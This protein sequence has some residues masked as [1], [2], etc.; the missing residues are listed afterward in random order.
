MTG[1][2]FMTRQNLSIFALAALARDDARGA[3]VFQ[4][5]SKDL[6]DGERI[7]MKHVYNAFGCGGKN[8][9]PELSWDNPPLGTKSFAV[10]AHDPDAPTG[11]AGFWHW[12][13]V[14]IPADIHNLKQNAGEASG[15]HL[16][17]GAQML[18]TDFAEKA[19]GGP[20][21]PP[22]APHRYV[23]TIYA[24]KIDKLGDAA[25]GRTA[26]AGFTIEQ[27]TLAKSSLTGFFGR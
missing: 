11:G 22:G 23:F 25:L 8:L 1:V 21:P 26:I 2:H 6:L 15:K 12:I 18:E 7:A 4:L 16:P 24:L 19:Y 14:D 27:N 20:C 10:L 5:K 13:V 17:I 3:E 9:S